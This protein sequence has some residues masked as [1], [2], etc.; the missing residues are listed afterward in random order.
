VSCDRSA[1]HGANAAVPPPAGRPF[2]DE[3]APAGRAPAVGESGAALPEVPPAVEN[4]GAPLPGGAGGDSASI[5]SGPADPPANG[6]AAGADAP[7]PE[8]PVG[9]FGMTDVPVFREGEDTGDYR[10]AGFGLLAGFEYDVYKVEASLTDGKPTLDVIPPTVRGLHGQPVALRGFMVPIDVMRNKART[11]LLVRNRL[12]CCF[13]IPTSVNEWVYIRM[14]GDKT[15]EYAKDIPVTVCGVLEV[16]ESI[17][18]GMVMSIYR[19]VAHDVTH[20]GGY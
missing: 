11:F 10:Q 2:R 8:S 12:A 1:E 17:S 3:P 15:A 6:G 9:M 19:M 7:A 13:G 20:E 18:D 4:V 5:A 16:G 14:E